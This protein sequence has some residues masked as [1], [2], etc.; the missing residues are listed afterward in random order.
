MLSCWACSN[1]SSNQLT[2]TLPDQ[3]YGLPKLTVI[4]VG[5]S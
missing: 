3:V 2:G 1:L 4:Q 5:W